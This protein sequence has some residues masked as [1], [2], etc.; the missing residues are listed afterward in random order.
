LRNKAYELYKGR[1]GEKLNPIQEDFHQ[2]V[3]KMMGT[4]MLWGGLGEEDR[5]SIVT[6]CKER[7]FDA[8]DRLVKK[9]DKGTGFYLILEG[10]VEVKSGITTLAKFGTGQ[11]F[12][13]MSLLDG[14]PR[15]ADVVALEPTRCLVL[16]PQE[17]N[18]IVDSNPR[19]ATA[20]LRELTRRLRAT[21]QSISE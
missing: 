12:G 16:N 8:G 9:G 11:F 2:A 3:V 20:M 1:K 4:T 7:S 13:E 15:S 21:T 6:L 18:Q 10:S 17:L 14:E 19:I 5:D